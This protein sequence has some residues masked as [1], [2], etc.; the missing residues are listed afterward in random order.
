MIFIARG[1]RGV[2]VASSMF[3]RFCRCCPCLR[4]FSP[5]RWVFLPFS[6]WRYF[7]CALRWLL[8][9]PSRRHASQQYAC[10]LQQRRQTQNWSPHHRHTMH[11]NNNVR[12]TS[13]LANNRKAQMEK[14]VIG[15][16]SFRMIA[17]ALMKSTKPMLRACIHN[18]IETSQIDVVEARGGGLM[19]LES[20]MTRP[21][22]TRL[23]LN[24]RNEK[25]FQSMWN[26]IESNEEKN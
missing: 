23:I 1:R 2:E 12:V 17:A 3:F 16:G 9:F 14:D 6:V 19:P 25:D 4:R 21:S 7:R 11:S 18:I 24:Q 15:S 22:Q 20:S 5:S 10:P 8:R 26:E 13:G